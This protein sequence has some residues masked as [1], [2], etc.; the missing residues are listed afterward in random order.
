MAQEHLSAWEVFRTVY[1]VA[2]RIFQD[3]LEITVSDTFLE[4][5][6][7]IPEV[8]A[9]YLDRE[10]LPFDELFTITQKKNTIY[11]HCINVGMYCL[12]LARELGMSAKEREDIFRG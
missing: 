3:Y 1:P 5:L 10:N 2:T 9:E 7:E 8:L 4:L 11:T 12:C 6:D